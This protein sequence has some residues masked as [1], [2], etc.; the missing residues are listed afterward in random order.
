MGGERAGGRRGGPEERI[1]R[2]SC[3]MRPATS[4]LAGVA[5][6]AGAEHGEPPVCVAKRRPGAS[7]PA[8]LIISLSE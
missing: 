3:L 5:A 1:R 6:E 4:G 8:R 2:K 7:G